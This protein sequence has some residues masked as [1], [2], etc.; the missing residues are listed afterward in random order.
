MENSKTDLKTPRFSRKQKMVAGGIGI[1]AISA[2]IYGVSEYKNTQ[3]P[4]PKV[5]DYDPEAEVGI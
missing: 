3:K 4:T 5:A 2:A 1:L